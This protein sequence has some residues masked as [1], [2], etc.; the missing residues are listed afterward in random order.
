MCVELRVRI[1]SYL[2][3]LG[4]LGIHKKSIHDLCYY[5]ALYPPGL[6]SPTY[7]HKL[8]SAY[9]YF[10]KKGS[11]CLLCVQSS[12]VCIRKSHPVIRCCFIFVSAVIFVVL[13]IQFRVV[14]VVVVVVVVF[15]LAGEGGGCHSLS[16]TL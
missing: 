5:F 9:F 11:Q 1:I 14:R 16:A 7:K 15:L 13:F 4:L 10:G 2:F 8:I 3:Q 12:C 6:P